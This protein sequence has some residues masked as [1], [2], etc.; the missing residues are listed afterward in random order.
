MWAIPYC[1]PRRLCWQALA[2]TG[3]E[4]QSL[5]GIFSP[6]SLRLI[7]FV[8]S[9]RT[10]WPRAAYVPRKAPLLGTRKASLLGRSVVGAGICRDL[11]STS[12]GFQE[13]PAALLKKS[14]QFSNIG[15]YFIYYPI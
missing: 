4:S 9:I 10:I 1:L 15:G 5:K 7:S 2:L 12:D 13:E 11:D 8:A 3:R 6:S 14:L